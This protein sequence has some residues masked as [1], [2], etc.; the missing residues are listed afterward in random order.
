MVEYN[1]DFIERNGAWMLSVFGIVS[2]C[3]SA[4]FVYFLKSRCSSIRCCGVECQRD[5]LD[6]A[7]IA[8]LDMNARSPRMLSRIQT[9]INSESNV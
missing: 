9:A 4:M 7:A 8:E 5:V 2:A 1:P 6:A 3:I